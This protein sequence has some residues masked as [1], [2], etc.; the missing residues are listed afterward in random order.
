[1]FLH[2]EDYD[3]LKFQALA[4]MDGQETDCVHFR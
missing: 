3:L 2:T 4:F 1:L